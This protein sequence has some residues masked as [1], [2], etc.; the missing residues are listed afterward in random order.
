MR[1]LKTSLKYLVLA[2]LVVCNVLPAQALSTVPYT[3]P[4]AQTAAPVIVTGYGFDGTNVTYVQLFN[5]SDGVVDLS[6]WQLEYRRADSADFNLLVKFDGLLKPSNY[7]IAAEAGLLEGADYSYVYAPP[8]EGVPTAVS[9]VFHLLPTP[10]YKSEDIKLPAKQEVSYWRRNISDTTGNYLSTFASFVP[11]ATDTLY[12]GGL[13]AFPDDA[14]LQ[15]SE[16]LANPRDCSPIDLAL[17]CHDYVKL[18]NPTTDPIDLSLFRLRSGYQGQSVTSSNTFMM[19]GLLQPGHYL[20][21]T[22]TADNRP[23]ALTNSGGYVWLED[24]YGVKLY[25]PTVQAYADASSDSHKGQ[26]WAYDESDGNWKWTSLP[27]PTDAPSV[28]PV[29]VATETT[30]ESSLT[31]CQPNQY[32]SPETNRCR[33]IAVPEVATLAACSAGQY[34]SPETNRCRN[35]EV[36]TSLTPCAEGEERNPA[37]NRCRRIASTESTLTPC[38]SNQER[39]PDTNRCRNK[40]VTGAASTT[41]FAV[42]PVGQS[43]AN[44]VGWWALG[45]ISAAAVAYGVW[46][47]HQELLQAGRRALRYLRISK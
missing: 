14:G 42:E 11:A 4:A 10:E 30:A 23:L 17:D 31:P 13:Y 36:A 20:P 12:G 3:P 21:V 15:V 32:R 40:V 39:N 35:V 29:I 7:V 6:G 5:K 47:W 27:T 8:S 28:F 46:E 16:V 9:T 34:R 43:A 45:G 33:L 19:S 22:L 18:Y 37:T 44:F 41:P 2:G 26:A 1:E 38:G 25:S 24:M